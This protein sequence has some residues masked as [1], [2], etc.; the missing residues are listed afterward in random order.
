MAR[1]SDIQYI[2]FYTDGSAA[3]QFELKPQPQKQ[4]Q[5]QRPR[6]RRQKRIV[7]HI[8]FLAVT[9]IVVAM[10]ML[11]LMI[12]GA[13][14]LIRANEQVALAEGY[15][16]EVQNENIQLRQTYCE[17]Y[18]LEEIRAEALEMGM[19]PAERAQTVMIHVEEMPVAEQTITNSIWTV[20]ASLF[21]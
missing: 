5:P 9:G 2:Q 17:S 10:V 20:L 19:I 6:P 14:G 7:V 18:D 21:A 12:S 8:D 16:A 1:K 13:S 4:P 11:V 15:L 3:R